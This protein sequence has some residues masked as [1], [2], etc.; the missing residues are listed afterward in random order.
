[1]S[2]RQKKAPVSISALARETGL[3]RATVRERLEKAKVAPK[4]VKAREKLYD[5]AEARAALQP[6]DRTGLRNAQTEKTA[7]EAERARIKLD[8]ERGELV[9]IR[10]VRADLQE[11]INRVFQRF[12]VAGPREIAPQLRG[13]KTAQI[14]ATLRR[15]AERFFSELRTEYE[16][17]L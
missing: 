14:E 6:D 16:G 12:A 2:T 17:Y 13:L 10:E 11:I 5:A 7:V 3:A 9:P 8:S 4:S 15:D 1:M